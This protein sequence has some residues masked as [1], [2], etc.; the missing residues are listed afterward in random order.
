MGHAGSKHLMLLAATCILEPTGHAPK[1]PR[2][3]MKMRPSSVSAMVCVPPHT[4][5]TTLQH[6]THVIDAVQLDFPDC[7][8]VNNKKVPG[9]RMHGSREREDSVQVWVA[10]G[11]AA[12]ENTANPHFSFWIDCTRVGRSLLDPV[13]SPSPSRPYLQ[14]SGGTC[15]RTRSGRSAAANRAPWV[16]SRPCR[17]GKIEGVQ[18]RSFKELTRRGPT[19]TP[20]QQGTRF[21]DSQ[22]RSLDVQRACSKGC[23]AAVA[24]SCCAQ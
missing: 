6:R 11:E 13:L 1:L 23:R 17:P 18:R 9:R 5:C 10:Q 22:L 16:L 4:A 2:P 19:R 24:T 3:Q 8:G 14:R 21:S 15:D 12:F 20:L 7:V